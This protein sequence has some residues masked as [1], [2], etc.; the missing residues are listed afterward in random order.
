MNL[1]RMPD[2]NTAALRQY[3]TELDSFDAESLAYEK[4][5]ADYEQELRSNPL[6]L[7][8]ATQEW[9]KDDGEQTLPTSCAEI[10][11]GVADERTR[12]VV[13]DTIVRWAIR[14]MGPGDFDTWRAK[15]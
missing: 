8:E 3:L 14:Y 13:I 7:F 1:S 11:C 12:K 9:M 4:D 15:Q 6:K 2:G 5:C 10:L